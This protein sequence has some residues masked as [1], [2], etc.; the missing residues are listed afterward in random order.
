MSSE[1]KRSSGTRAK[2]RKFCGNRFTCS[3]NA[4][5]S[6]ISSSNKKLKMDELLPPENEINQPN[7]PNFDGYRIVD[8]NSFFQFLKLYL[9]CK[10]CHGD[11]SLEEVL[12][13]GLSSKFELICKTCGNK[14]IR[15]STLIGKTKNVPEINRRFIYAMRVIGKG[16]AS[17]KKFCAVMDLPPPV[18]PKSYN[19]VVHKILN[20]SKNV[21]TKSMRKAAQAEAILSNSSLCVTVS[22]DGTWK[23]RGHT[24]LTGACSVIGAESGK[25][26]DVE[27]MSSFCKACEYS[28]KKNYVNEDH[29]KVCLKN[30]FS[31]AGQMEVDGM[32]RI[33]KRSEN[34]RGV[35]YINYIGDGDARTYKAVCDSSPYGAVEIRKIEC[36]AHVQKRMG[37]RLRKL[38]Q[39]KKEKL[40]DG[41]SLGGK[42]RLTDKVIDQV[43]KYY[44]NAIRGNKE[45]LSNMRRSIWAIFYHKRSTDEFPMHDFCP[46]GP[47]TWCKYKQAKQQGVLFTHKSSIPIAIMDAIKPIFLDLSDPK[48]LKRCI[49]GHTQNPNESFNSLIWNFCPKTS[50]CG[51]SIVNIAVQEAVIVFN[52][53]FVGRHYVMDELQ[54]L[55]SRFSLEEFVKFDKQ[56]I[57]DAE[58]QAVLD[59]KE[60]RKLRKHSR[61][62]DEKTFVEKH[63]EAYS[64]GN[65]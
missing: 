5:D 2:K 55:R 64:P 56:R 57:A 62:A 10:Q 9:C 18:A 24:S 28:R 29:A 33:F 14:A 27:I 8:I 50:G 53:G 35:K 39:E 63:G 11:I 52:D 12:V 26:I 37:S 3:S 20:A 4:D 41:K 32:V 30:H 58:R 21:A 46:D 65:F 17:M 40:Q 59:T 61:L 19:K 22:G 47:D 43:T 6:F 34:D 13:Y 44:G 15:S 51:P 7:A 23:T 1:Q 16:H 42:G 38:K 48:L 36:V 60:Q 31:S 54:L 49:G 45:S 25:V